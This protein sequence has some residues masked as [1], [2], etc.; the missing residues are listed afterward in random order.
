VLDPAAKAAGSSRFLNKKMVHLLK[1]V[2]IALGT[3]V[4]IIIAHPEVDAGNAAM[5]LAFTEINRIQNLMSVYSSESEVSLLNKNGFCAG[6][7]DDTRQ[8]I[9]KSNYYS[10]LS[11]GVFDITILPVLELWENKIKLHTFPSDEEI[12]E[13]QKLVDYR[14]LVILNN[15]VKF[16]KEGMKVTLA[17]AAKGYA[18]DK[19]IETLIKCDIKNALVNAGGDIRC[20]GGKTDTL[21]WKIAIR[22][23]LDK[24][25]VCTVLDMRDRAIAT[26]GTYQRSYND[27]IDPR[28][29]RPVEQDVVSA[30]VL[31]NSALDAD[32]L[33]KCLFVPGITK[34][35]EFFSNLSGIEAIAITRDGS[36]V[37]IP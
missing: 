32:I 26:S 17:G 5:R 2:K 7:S 36:I 27:I 34:A 28:S 24:R 12:L 29:G 16:N 23:P 6:L 1:D 8:V 22:D 14:N 10:K 11:G 35:R 21:P 30:S 4:T 13:K 9:Q 31:A 18:V 3:F 20:V 15:Q 37:N 33:T 19:A 25:R